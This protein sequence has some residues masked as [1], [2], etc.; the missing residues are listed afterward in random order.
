MLHTQFSPVSIIPPILHTQF[1]LSVSFHQCSIL[2]F[3]LSVS[4]HQCS[5][6]IFIH[7]LMLIR[8]RRLNLWTVFR[9]L[10]LSVAV[11]QHNHTLH[12]THHRPLELRNCNVSSKF[13]DTARFSR[14][15]SS[16]GTVHITL[17]VK[18]NMLMELRNVTFNADTVNSYMSSPSQPYNFLWTAQITNLHVIQFSGTPQL[19]TQSRSPA[20][21]FGSH[22]I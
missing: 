14:C 21:L 13:T 11:L 12:Y 17:R 16:A 15:V 22:R 3:P 6:L 20:P 10:A 18:T 19:G 2:S 7:I 5:I 8:T 9:P 1:P 4:F